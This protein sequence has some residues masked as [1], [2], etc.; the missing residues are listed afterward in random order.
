MKAAVSRPSPGPGN[1]PAARHPAAQAYESATANLEDAIQAVE[2]GD[3]A[4][5]QRAVQQAIDAVT[6]LYLELGHDGPEDSATGLADLFGYIVGRILRIDIFDDT[7]F[8]HQALELTNVLY[9]SLGLTTSD[10]FSVAVTQRSAANRKRSAAA[11]VIPL[12]T[13][14]R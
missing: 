13:A 9:T 10:G 4:A 12:E 3:T 14:P 11:T 2:T 7:R 6:C 1:G 5:R 8:A